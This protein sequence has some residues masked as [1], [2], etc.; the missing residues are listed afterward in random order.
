MMFEQAY[1][2]DLRSQFHKVKQHAEDAIAQIS[3]DEL[4]ATL[5]TESNSL[6]VLMKHMAG[7]LRSR[8]TGFLTTNGEKPDRNRDGEF[9]IQQRPSRQAILEHWETG[10]RCLFNTLDTLSPADLSREVEIRSERLSVIQALNRALVHQAEHAGQIVFL[11]KH[12][13]SSEWKTLSIP[14]RRA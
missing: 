12:Q 13:R 5:D 10:W 9:E 11:A 6:A 8:F 7:N 14:R 4:F 2:D 3:D 1:L